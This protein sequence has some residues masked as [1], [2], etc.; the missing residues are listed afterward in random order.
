MDLKLRPPGGVV[1][2]Q[3]GEY[4]KAVGV[5]VRKSKGKE[6][7]SRTP[8]AEMLPVMVCARNRPALATHVVPPGSGLR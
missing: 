3:G 6:A 5:V 1:R 7:P 4:C 8:G 2:E